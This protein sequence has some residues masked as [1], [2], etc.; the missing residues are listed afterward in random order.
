MKVSSIVLNNFT[1]DNRVLKENLSLKKAGYDTQIIAM[2]EGD[3]KQKE[4]VEG[5]PVSRIKLKTK[6]WSKSFIISGIKYF[7]FV[8]KAM[9]I[10]KGSKIV[11]CNDIETLPIG[12]IRK[13]LNRKT[14][15]VYDA[16]E[17]EL[18]KSS[19]SG[20]AMK[21]LN[22]KMEKWFIKS[23]DAV[24]SVSDS[25]ANEYVRLYDIEK[26]NLIF[27]CPPKSF[28]TNEGYDI[29]RKKFN[30]R[31][32]QN[33]FIYQG[34]F[35][36]SR[37]IELIID[38]FL[39]FED[40]KNV[41]VFMGFGKLLNLVQDACDKSD[42]IFY[43]EGVAFNDI[44]KHTKSADWGLITT[45]N[46]C[47]NNYMSLPN[48]LFEYAMADIPIL[49][50]PNI[51]MKTKIENYNIGLVSKSETVKD[52]AIAIKKAGSTNK[53]QYSQGLEKIRK[54]FN[55]ENQEKK[56]IDIYNNL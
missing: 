20:P 52:L 3:L 41:M 18:E 14:K 34:G 48:K 49:A 47:L 25:I 9:R 16:H 13:K 53:Q 39:S 27:N 10:T 22:R 38:A 11:H 51:E 23:C 44:I 12:F 26:P 55:W 21:W 46:I 37:G 36:K 15:L 24:I 54:E 2:H 32:D 6:D 28:Y 33:I 42:K 43:H 50:F 1:R 56:L 31:K 7:E 8:I 17:Y 19:G 30:I 45:Q 40:D 5:I 35:S 4:I 29:F